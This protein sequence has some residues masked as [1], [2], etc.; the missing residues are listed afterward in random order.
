MTT[1]LPQFILIVSTL[2]ASWLGMQA[3]HE[4]GHVLGATVTG[5]RVSRVVLHPLTISR[6]DLV[7]NPSPLFVVWAGPVFGVLAPLLLWGVAAALGLS[8]TFPFRFSLVSSARERPLP[9]SAH[10]R[11]GDAGDMFAGAEAWH[12]WLFG[13]DRAARLCLWHGQ[14]AHS[15]SAPR[16]ES[17]IE[18]L[19]A[20]DRYPLAALVFDRWRSMQVGARVPQRRPFHA[21]HS[22]EPYH[23]RAIIGDI[24]AP[25]TRRDTKVKDFLFTDGCR[26]TDDT[27]HTRSPTVSCRRDYVDLSTITSMPTRKPASAAFIQWAAWRRAL[28]KLNGSSHAS[29]IGCLRLLRRCWRSGAE[30]THAT[31]KSS[32]L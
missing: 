18:W 30:V 4:L 7:D 19:T 3:V 2:L 9:A 20:P 8:A 25:L 16:G 12:L 1:R 14:G 22:E 5:G 10:S 29:A 31:C 32:A 26:F 6:T 24:T 15:A 11:V 21:K 27:V 23:A 13:F 17:I 28:Y